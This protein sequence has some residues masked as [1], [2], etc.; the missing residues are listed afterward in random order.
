MRKDEL[1]NKLR[2]LDPGA[3]LTIEERELA[4]MFGANIV[5][6]EV[7]QAIEAFAL[8]HRCSFSHHAHGLTVPCFEKDDIF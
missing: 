2:H 6:P 3:T 5:S 1:A 8:E 4:E 7:V